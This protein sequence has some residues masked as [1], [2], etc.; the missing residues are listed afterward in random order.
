MF[1]I[2]IAVVRTLIF[3][4][5]LLYSSL[6]YSNILDKKFNI[7][8]S[9]EIAKNRCS[10]LKNNSSYLTLKDFKWNLHINKLIK[11]S[12]KLYQ[13]DK[14]L[15]DRVYYDSTQKNFVLPVRMLDDTVKNIKLSENFIHNLISHVE[16]ALGNH[17]VDEINFTD[18][19]HSHFLIPKD[20]YDKQIALIKDHSVV[21]ER[22]FNLE[23]ILF[24][25]HTAEQLDMEV[26]K[27]NGK[28]HLPADDYLR[29]RYLTRNII[30]YNDGSNKLEVAQV[31]NLGT[32]YNTVGTPDHNKY[33]W[34]GAG[35][36]M[37]ASYKGCFPFKKEGQVY[38]FDMSLQGPDSLYVNNI[39]NDTH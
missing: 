36:Y 33:H 3:I 13:S 10:G 39:S 1:N 4:I 24:V 38:Y 11:L 2:Y 12:K 35:Y 34:W 17:Y 6:S 21:Y 28:Y 23:E 19:G 20:Y 30:G 7:N 18:M 25:Y 26:E 9:I 27:I 31:E 22:I 16:M 8:D 15:L 14:R 37:H 5:F 32:E 29:H